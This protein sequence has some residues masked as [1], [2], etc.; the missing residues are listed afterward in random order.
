MWEKFDANYESDMAKDMKALVAAIEV[1]ENG[2]YM[3]PGKVVQAA[4]IAPLAWK[5]K[6]RIAPGSNVTLVAIRTE[7]QR[8]EATIS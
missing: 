4:Q 8:T 1:E 2:F 3:A 6:P 5:K 7:L